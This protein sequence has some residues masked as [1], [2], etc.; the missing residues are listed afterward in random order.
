MYFIASLLLFSL[1][2]QEYPKTSLS[3]GKAQ[4]ICCQS[5]DRNTR[6]CR[7]C[8]LFIGNQRRDSFEKESGAIRKTWNVLRGVKNLPV[9]QVWPLLRLKE[10]TDW[11]RNWG[12]QYL[13]CA[14]GLWSHCLGHKWFTSQPWKGK[15]KTYTITWMVLLWHYRKP[16]CRRGQA[17]LITSCF[18]DVALL[19]NWRF[20]TILS[21]ASLLEPF[22]F[23]TALLTSCLCHVLA[24][25]A[26]FQTFS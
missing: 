13:I 20:V 17:N 3:R 24:I 12:L 25:L 2:P 7:A 4:R 1:L 11:M 22:F 6:V 21:Q 5:E 9:H 15:Y 23:L 19:T 16:C 18:A 26:I 14:W 8:P 10:R